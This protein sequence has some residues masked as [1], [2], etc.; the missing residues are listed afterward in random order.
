M[1]PRIR[2]LEAYVRMKDYEDVFERKPIYLIVG[3]DS[4]RL[5]R[6]ADF[7]LKT[8]SVKDITYATALY[9]DV[10]EDPFSRCWTVLLDN[11]HEHISLSQLGYKY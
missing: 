3:R 4:R 1:E 10:M 6:I 2:K 11:I 9:E 8:R 7:I 5:K